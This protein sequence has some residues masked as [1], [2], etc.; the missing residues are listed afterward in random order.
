MSVYRKD[1]NGN[2]K[3]IAGS[4]TQRINMHIFQT[5]HEFDT[6]KN[7][8][9]YIINESDAKPYISSI[10]DWTQYS[11]NLSEPNQ[12][13][14]INIKLGSQT[15]KLINNVKNIEIGTLKGV[16]QC[17]TEK[18]D[19]NEIFLDVVGTVV[20][21]NGVEKTSINTDTTPTANSNNLI[22]SG[23]VHDYPAIVFA[24]SE[25]QKSKNLCGLIDFEQTINGVTIKLISSSQTVILNGT[26]T[27]TFDAMTTV[28]NM[29]P[30]VS[31]MQGEDLKVTAYYL[32]GTKS[33]TAIA[34]ISTVD[35]DDVF[36][37]RSAGIAL[38]DNNST[39]IN[40]S[41]SKN[42]TYNTLMLY[43]VNGASFTNYM[44]R[45]QIEKGQ[46]TNWEYPHGQITHNGDKEIVFAES[47]RQ[48]SKNLL[49][50]EDIIPKTGLTTDNNGTFYI[51]TTGYYVIQQL[52]IS[53]ELN[54]TYTMSCNVVSITGGNNPTFEFAVKYK[55]GEWAGYGSNVITGTGIASASFTPTKEV[56][57]FE[58]RFIRQNP[59]GQELQATI[60][61]L[62]LEEGSVATDYQ[63][64]NGQITHSGDK[65]IEFAES[66]RQKSKNLLN[67]NLLK[68]G[69]YIFVTG[70]YDYNDDYV[71]F[72]PISVTP[73]STI[74]VSCNGFIFN[75][76]CGFVFFNN[77]V[78]VGYLS[79]GAT[80]A[81]V[82][83]NANQVI[84]NFLKVGITKDDVQYAQ[85]EY[86]STATDYQPYNGQITHNGDPA[87]EFAESERQKSKNLLDINKAELKANS[88]TDSTLS[89]GT[90]TINNSEFCYISSLT[91]L[92]DLKPN[93]PYTLSYVT[94]NGYSYI[95]QY[96]DGS[97]G[98]KWNNGETKI[99]S[100]VDIDRIANNLLLFY[101]S[102]NSTVTYSN[103]QI[104]EGSTATDYQPYNGA[105]VHKSEVEP[106][107][108]YDKDTKNTIGG[109]PYTNGIGDGNAANYTINNIDL[110]PYKYMYVYQRMF[111]EI[112]K[113]FV[114]LTNSVEAGGYCGGQTTM[115]YNIDALDCSLVKIPTTK[116]SITF[117]ARYIK[118]SDVSIQSTP[119]N[120]C[121]IEGYK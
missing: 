55:D 93:I 90:L 16:I 118:L 44:F 18:L 39:S 42:S 107:L 48:K 6:V 40:F 33:D 116:N 25:R 27:S 112:Q 80:V 117:D 69:C 83:A 24:E 56:D 26:A 111:G 94:N 14:N 85:L 101:G 23:G 9:N 53:F 65:E 59:A 50:Y 64:Y 8:D 13:S 12:S 60:N 70:Q 115:S 52:N 4:L 79:N 95:Y 114:D 21:L 17:H 38:P 88:Q 105:I 119:V 81:T 87:V 99:F 62:Q 58:L 66:E 22:T 96:Y 73:N 98:F 36:G 63:P 68:K 47:E 89:N 20:S 71:T 31:N 102:T 29:L 5:T 49:N 104:E 45:I 54:K 75:S 57:L 82:P 10:K 41:P 2:I 121:R 34:F 76:D 51:D 37:D 110:T 86:G 61:N 77:G 84:Y 28:R 74:T 32:S 91:N 103:I 109:K 67:K 35:N 46:V 72:E 78:F 106:I 11:I 30:Y 108:I 92:C 120:V 3:K 43:T 15:L 113:I 100:Q 97:T 1:D 19:N 7:E